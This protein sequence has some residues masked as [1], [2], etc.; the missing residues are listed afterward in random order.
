MRVGFHRA[1]LHCS[2]VVGLAALL[3]TSAAAATPGL[4]LLNPDATA[5]DL[6]GLSVALSGDRAVV[7]SPVN[8]DS[9]GIAYVYERVNGAWAQTAKLA[10]E[11]NLFAYG[12]PVAVSGN[13]IVIGSVYLAGGSLVGVANVFVQDGDAWLP[14]GRLASGVPDDNFGSAVAI[15]D[16][17]ILV[18]ANTTSSAGRYPGA[19]HVFV[20]QGTN[21]QFQQ[22]LTSGR[23]FLGHSVAVHGDFAAAG[24]I[25]DDADGSAY[26]FTRTN[27][28]WTLEKTLTNAGPVVALSGETFVVGGSLAGGFPPRPGA[29]QVYVRSGGQWTFQQK[30]MPSDS[31]IDDA[32]GIA[33]SIDGDRIVVGATHEGEE[34]DNSG[35]AYRF[36][37]NG[38]NWL[39]QDKLTTT[40]S[41]ARRGFGR[42]VGISAGMALVGTG[43]SDYLSKPGAAFIF[44]A[45]PSNQPPAF[46]LPI[47]P[48]ANPVVAGRSVRLSTLA[49]DLDRRDRLSYLW[50]FGDGTTNRTGSRTTKKYATPGTYDVYAVV[51]DGRGGSATS[52][53]QQVFVV[54]TGVPYP[55]LAKITVT[56]NFAKPGLD[57]IR[58]SGQWPVP[59]G[60]PLEGKSFVL[61]FGPIQRAFTLDA[62][63]QAVLVN[64]RVT[65]LKPRKGLAKFSAKLTGDFR[66]LLA[67]LGMTDAAVRNVDATTPVTITFDGVPYD[68]DFVL[69]Y[70][71][72]AGRSGTAK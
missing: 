47:R 15:H 70:S 27:G 3:A 4:R 56:V 52:P 43:D 32:F 9:A 19:V 7:V 35:R 50:H 17:T 42:S 57:T 36:I 2:A 38:T 10:G 25:I 8:N 40:V 11:G 45:V 28:V 5:G 49:V 72:R 13:T 46:L 68:E 48:S 24:S 12:S 60:T 69:V 55:D 41:S 1:A 58:V 6:F 21:W 65:V 22:K 71:A 14:Q 64:G 51:S 30:L 61:D 16:D 23:S 34:S 62:R 63:G 67:T 59:D 53:T 26:L 54:Q 18:S 37:R 44:A 29:A 20:R 31:S 39:E 33:V 66:D